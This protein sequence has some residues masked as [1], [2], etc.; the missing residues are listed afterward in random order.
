MGEVFHQRFHIVVNEEL[1][2]KV[3]EILG[4]EPKNVT[5]QDITDVVYA[6]VL[7]QE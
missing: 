7:G 5:E 4:K 3:A 2:N 6:K 1:R